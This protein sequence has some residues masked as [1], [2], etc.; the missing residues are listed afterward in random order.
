MGKQD[1]DLPNQLRNLWMKKTEKTTWNFW[2]S[3]LRNMNIDEEIISFIDSSFSSIP[4]RV[5]QY[6]IQMK[7]ELEPKFY[8]TKGRKIFLFP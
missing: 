3:S 6:V 1:Y 8:S 5:Q 2:N 4:E 7:N